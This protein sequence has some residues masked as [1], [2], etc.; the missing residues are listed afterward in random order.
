MGR[1]TDQPS[2]ATVIQPNFRTNSQREA[3]HAEWRS[4]I[5]RGED[6]KQGLVQKVEATPTSSFIEY[7]WRK[8]TG[9]EKTTAQEKAKKEA[10]GEVA[11]LNQDGAQRSESYGEWEKGKRK[12]R[13]HDRVRWGL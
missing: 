7:W 12:E 5:A 8:A 1:I 13:W 11:L 4:R 10:Q 9:K 3:L 6:P 2:H